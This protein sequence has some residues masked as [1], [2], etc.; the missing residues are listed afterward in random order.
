MSSEDLEA[1]IKKMMEKACDLIRE[2]N[3]IIEKRLSEILGSNLLDFNCDR[4]HCNE[5][6]G[7]VF[8]RE[9]LLDGV[10]I[11]DVRQNKETK[12]LEMRS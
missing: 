4:L 11:L 1:S 9:Y 3:D 6:T 2:R 5:Y 12:M 10:I 8:H 7:M